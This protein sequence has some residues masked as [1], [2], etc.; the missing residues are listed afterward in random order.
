MHLSIKLLSMMFFLLLTIFISGC[1]YRIAAPYQIPDG[2]AIEIGKNEAKLVRSQLSIHKNVSH[3]IQRDLAWPINKR[4]VNVLRLHIGE[5]A[6]REASRNSQRASTRWTMTLHCSAVFRS[7]HL[8]SGEV[9]RDF[10]ATAS[11]SKLADEI[12]AIERASAE[13]ALQIR[14]WLETLNYKDAA[15]ALKKD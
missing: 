12:N 11:V 14:G 1:S 13:M 10:H 3:S 9:R 15:A 6:M 2:I 7:P 5:D 4:S 8:E